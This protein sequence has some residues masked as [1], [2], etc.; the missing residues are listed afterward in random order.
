MGFPTAGVTVGETMN[1][2][3]LT[4]MTPEQW[5]AIPGV[6]VKNAK[7]IRHFIESPAVSAVIEQLMQQKLPAFNQAG[8]PRPLEISV[9]NQGN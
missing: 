5:Q 6:G 4:Q 9:Q 3:E 2:F 1:W 8:H 7:K